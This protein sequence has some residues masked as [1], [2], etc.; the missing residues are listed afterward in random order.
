MTAGRLD[1]A[2]SEIRAALDLRDTFGA[3]HVATGELRKALKELDCLRRF[4]RPRP[5]RTVLR[6]EKV[7]RHVPEAAAAHLVVAVGHLQ[8]LA[9]EGL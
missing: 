3:N 8:R 4:Q 2:Q 5:R 6:L 1:A 9:E 7:A